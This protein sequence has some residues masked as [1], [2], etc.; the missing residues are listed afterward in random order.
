MR[1]PLKITRLVAWSQEDPRGISLLARFFHR[2]FGIRQRLPG[3][4]GLLL[5]FTGAIGDMVSLSPVLRAL[6]HQHPDTPICV[7]V[8]G[9]GTG[10]ILKACPYV[11]QIVEFCLYETTP[12]KWWEVLKALCNIVWR[13]RYTTA[14]LTMGTGWLPQYRIWA[15]LLLYASGARRRLAFRD[16]SDLWR[17]APAPISRLPL[18][19]EIIEASQPQRTDRFMELFRKAGLICGAGHVATEVWTSEDDVREAE[20][21]DECFAGDGDG[22]PVVL[23]FPGVGSGP[24]KRWPPGRYVKVVS[25][26]IAMYGAHMFL[27]GMGHDHPLCKTIA[28][29]VPSC[30]NLAGRHSVGALFVLIGR[31][32]LVIA[33]DSGPV[34]IAAATETP[35]VA[36]FGPTNPQVWAPKSSCLTI[37]RTS[38]CPPCG[39]PYFCQS[40]IDFACTTRV[41][42]SDV[43]QACQ[44]ALRTWKPQ[45]Q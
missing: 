31:A 43:M 29:L 35:A 16:E 45:G 17:S 7:T 41:A 12:Y 32:D 3:R 26:L 10:S 42:V 8:K 24:G 38:D 9:S 21:L 2:V 13:R 4:D 37:L 18:A 34:H 36:I 5:I 44:H 23:V 39:N 27:D 33:S 25:N 6:A 14:V 28:A 1:I 20:R 15:L 22:R 19:N 11:D 30:R 40:E